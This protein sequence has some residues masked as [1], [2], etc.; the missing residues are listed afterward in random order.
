MCRDRSK[1]NGSGGLNHHVAPRCG[2][3][4]II[5][6]T[7]VEKQNAA[8]VSRSYSAAPATRPIAEPTPGARRSAPC[9]SGTCPAH[10]DTEQPKTA[11][12]RQAHL[13]KGLTEADGAV[14]LGREVQEADHLVLKPGDARA[15]DIHRRRTA[16]MDAYPQNA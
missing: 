9:R 6:L 8:D 12:V 10:P 1:L 15:P 4:S 3:E 11:K 7:L 16:Q 5:P 13:A 14:A 2:K